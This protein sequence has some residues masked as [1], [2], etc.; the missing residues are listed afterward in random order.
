MAKGRKDSKGRVLHK[1]ETYRSEDGLYRF[2]YSDAYGKRTSVYSKDLKQLREKEKNILRNQLDGLD[3]YAMGKSNVNSVFDRYISTKT[4]L[5]SSTKSN[6]IYTYN[7]YVREGFGKKKIANI[8]NSDVLILYRLLVNTGLGISTVENVHTV[9]HPTF[10]LAVRDQIIRNNPTD[11]VMAE[12]KKTTKKNTGI[13]RALTYEQTRCFLEYLEGSEF[14]RWKNLFTVMFGTGCRVGEIIGLRWEDI[15]L[16]E[17]MININHGITY[18]PRVDNSFK[19]EYEVSLPKTEKGIRIIPMLDEV[20]NALEDE[21]KYQECTGERCEFTIDGMEGFIFY[22]RYHSIHNPASINRVIKRIV[23]KYNADEILKA[24]REK[25]SPVLLPRFSCHITRHT[26]CSR[27][28]ENETNVKVIQ[29]VMGHKD[30][31]TTLDIYAE[32]SNQKKREVFEQLNSKG[33]L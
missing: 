14:V 26:F 11:G 21:R 27:L 29:E 9:L 15:D 18:Y 3:I 16:K 23:D 10:Q 20:Y 22:N 4:E 32:V 2:T 31:Q 19:C 1:G 25:R 5:R 30:I 33:V 13:R 28:C 12:L 24:K 8:K 6:Y 17:R 7:Q